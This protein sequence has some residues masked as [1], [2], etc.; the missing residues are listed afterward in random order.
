MSI[1]KRVT[2]SNYQTFQPPT[3][4]KRE[5]KRKKY[6]Y[7]HIK[8]ERIL[9]DKETTNRERKNRGGGNSF[10]RETFLAW[11]RVLIITTRNESGRARLILRGGE[12]EKG[13]SLPRDDETIMHAVAVKCTPGRLSLGF[14][15]GRGG[16]RRI[17]EASPCHPLHSG[18]ADARRGRRP[19][20]EARA[21]WWRAWRSAKRRR[22]KLDR[23]N[24]PRWA[25]Y[26][27]PGL[28][29]SPTPDSRPDIPRPG[30]E[31]PVWLIVHDYSLKGI[32]SWIYL[33]LGCE[34]EEWRW[35][36]WNVE[37]NRDVG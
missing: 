23:D 18:F 35:M 29:T 25:P 1:E 5:K 20:P 8:S 24:I 16:W 26:A 33:V 37:R 7:T 22:G 11:I 3:K 12:C 10:V 28:P 2:N 27:A 32:Y 17:R 13:S 21:A 30:N 15:G 19:R 36:V 4:I 6:V 34:K 14:C 9:P 31:T